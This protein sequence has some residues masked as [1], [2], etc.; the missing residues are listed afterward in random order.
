MIR[1]AHPGPRLRLAAAALLLAALAAGCATPPQTQRVIGERPADL[2]SGAELEEVPFFAQERYQCGPATLA[3]VLADIGR[4]VQPE[5]FVEQ[6]YVPEKQGSLRTEM[7][8]AVRAQGAVPYPVAG[9]L[10]AVFREIAAGRPVLVMQ[11]LGLD[12]W[13]RWHYAVAVGYDLDERQIVLRSGTERR[14]VTP[15]ATFERTWAR[16]DRWAQVIVPPG[17]PPATASALPWLRAVHELEQTGQAEAALV[18]YRAATERWP[19]NRPAW[20]A[21]GNGAYGQG[22]ARQARSAFLR[23]VELDREASDGWNNL[24]Y[25]LAETGCG[26]AALE[27]AECAV[28]LAPDD[29]AAR[30]TL[31]ELSRRSLPQALEASCDIPAC[32]AGSN[33]E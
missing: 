12:F 28:Q 1:C 29:D 6:V 22:D 8:A 15:L 5:Q 9:E 17:E 32:P 31:D 7:R 20:M 24:A 4:D 3:M 18:G 26:S 14:R 11:N 27:A 16:A 33:G 21:R 30:S 10:D 19:D 25:T 2:P 23:A 13:P